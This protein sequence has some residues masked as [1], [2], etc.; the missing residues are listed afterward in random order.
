MPTF[1]ERVVIDRFRRVIGKDKLIPIMTPEQAA[2]ELTHPPRPQYYTVARGDNFYV[3]GV[4]HG[5]T[6]QQIKNLNPT[7]D[8][9]KLQPGDQVRLPDIL[10]PLTIVMRTK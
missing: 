10:A 8:P 1:R 6:V 7:L 5:L 9:A 2:Q 4:R 3:I